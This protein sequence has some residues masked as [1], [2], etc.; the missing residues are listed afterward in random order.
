MPQ[1]DGEFREVTCGCA[2]SKTLMFMIDP[3]TLSGCA[4]GNAIPGREGGANESE[5]PHCFSRH[6]HWRIEA[7]CT[8]ARDGS[9]LCRRA[10]DIVLDRVTG[11]LQRADSA[12]RWET[13]RT[14]GTERRSRQ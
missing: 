1:D 2:I 5:P 3:V 10:S 6:Q 7:A 8:T 14:L 12:I 9:R 13:A 4:G 11:A